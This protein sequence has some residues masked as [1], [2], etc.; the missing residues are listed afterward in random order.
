MSL[1]TLREATVGGCVL[2][3]VHAVGAEW[4]VLVDETYQ[5]GDSGAHVVGPVGGDPLAAECSLTPTGEVDLVDAL[6]RSVQDAKRR[7]EA[8]GR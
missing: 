3:A 7:R 2:V 8:G 4:A 6:R 1:K 5:V